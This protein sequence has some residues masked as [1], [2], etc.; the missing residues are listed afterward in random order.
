MKCSKNLGSKHKK[1]YK[2]GEET[3]NNKLD[4]ILKN[5]VK[6]TNIGKKME[7]R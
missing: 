2:R 6:G 4:Q 5:T 7:F 1:N 3:E